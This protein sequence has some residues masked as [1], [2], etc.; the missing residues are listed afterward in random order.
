MC[1]GDLKIVENLALRELLE[2]GPK[3][4]ERKPVDWEEVE[5]EVMRTLRELVVEWGDQRRSD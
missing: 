4:R 2:R 5:E 3:Y 1:T